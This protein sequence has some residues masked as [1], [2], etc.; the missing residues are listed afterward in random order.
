MKTKMILGSFLLLVFAVH[1]SAEGSA[2]RYVEPGG[3]FSFSVPTGWTLREVPGVK[4]KIA[5]GTAAGGFAPNINV[6]DEAFTGSL[7]D[8]V[9]NGLTMLPKLYESVGNTQVKILSKNQFVT[10]SHKVGFRVLIQF[11]EPN[12]KLIRQTLYSFDGKDGRKLV[13]TCSVLGDGGESYDAA[14]DTAMKTFEPGR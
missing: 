7:E 10:A 9:S 8:Y 11:M 12:R 2:Q 1:A 5:F 4:Y 3:M 6:V 13:V 14:F